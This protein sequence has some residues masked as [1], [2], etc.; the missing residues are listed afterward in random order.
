[1]HFFLF[2]TLKSGAQIRVA[3]LVRVRLALCT[4]VRGREHPAGARRHIRGGCV[5]RC[6][7]LVCSLTAAGRTDEYAVGARQGEGGGVAGASG[8]CRRAGERA[9]GRG[10]AVD[11][12]LVAHVVAHHPFEV[13]PG[14]GARLDGRDREDRRG[15][16]RLDARALRRG[17]A[18]DARC[19]ALE[20]CPPLTVSP[21]S[22]PR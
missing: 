6:C 2:V 17:L 12:R 9:H 19:L 21:R 22:I 15:R 11:R 10:G 14:V 7:L 4:G 18:A 8:V 1:M 20:P 13:V 16:L 5:S 3:G